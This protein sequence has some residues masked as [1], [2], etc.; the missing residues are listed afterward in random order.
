MTA[1]V[2]HAARAATGSAAADARLFV[3]GFTD[4]AM[5]VMADRSVADELRMGRFRDVFVAAF[6]LPAIGEDALGRHW[7]EASPDQQARFLQVFEQQQVLI[8]AGR[9]NYICREKLTVGEVDAGADGT[10][11]V[12]SRV[13]RARA[14]P[15]PVDWTVDGS[16]G[17]W[18][19]VDMAI[20]DVEMSFILRTDFAAVLQSNGDRFDGLLVAM[21]KKVEE[22]KV[23]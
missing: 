9:F 1:F 5:A 14:K 13:E 20:D 16:I 21:Q 12:A 10:C 19:I 7:H 15:I 6:D 4:E 22:L 2:A 8:F 18:Q 3:C 23:G 11:R 17:D